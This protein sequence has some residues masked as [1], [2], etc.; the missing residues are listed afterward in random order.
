MYYLSR[1]KFGK[2]KSIR[3][4]DLRLNPGLNII[5]GPNGSGKTNLLELFEII[6]S[7]SFGDFFGE[8]GYDLNLTLEAVNQKKHAPMIIDVVASGAPNQTNAIPF[9]TN[10]KNVFEVEYKI[11]FSL[12]VEKIESIDGRTTI[13]NLIALILH[14]IGRNLIGYSFNHYFFRHAI[15]SPEPTLDVPGSVELWQNSIGK[16]NNYKISSIFS[17]GSFSDIV[18]EYLSNNNTS[19]SQFLISEKVVSYFENISDVLSSFTSIE[20]VRLAESLRFYINQEGTKFENIQFEFKI[21]GKWLHWNALSDGTKRMFLII[22]ELMLSPSDSIFLLEEPEL[23]IHPHQ[24][25]RLISFIRDEAQHKQI[26]LTTHSPQ[27]LDVLSKK[28][29]DHIIVTEMIDGRS[30]FRHLSAKESEKAIYYMENEAFLS[31]YWQFSDL[32]TID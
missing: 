22:S 11:S 17:V 6:M 15:I 21:A 1:V 2:Y 20:G 26:L 16:L 13:N 30:E 32:E 5:I 19:E 12:G 23:G 28:E 8:Q 7:Y 18:K 3:E 27:V 31:D 29:L 10:F 14:G 4:L 9:L 24:L 25:H